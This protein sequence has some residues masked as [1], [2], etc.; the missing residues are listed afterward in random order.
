[1]EVKVYH[2]VMVV[3]VQPVVHATV[4]LALPRHVLRVHQLVVA[5]DSMIPIH[6]Q[7]LV[8]ILEPTVVTAPLH[9]HCPHVLQVHQQVVVMDITQ[10]THVQMLVVTLKVTVVTVPRLVP[11]P[12][13]PQAPLMRE[14]E[15]YT[16]HLQLVVLISVDKV[17]QITATITALTLPALTLN[18][19]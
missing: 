4:M 13:V 3:E 18:L 7:I 15:I 16:I 12:P 17:K 6:V 10:L 8:G 19:K 14:Q 9:V 11:H 1:M 2:V 5:M